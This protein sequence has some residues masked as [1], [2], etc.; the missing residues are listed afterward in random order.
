MVEISIKL[1]HCLYEKRSPFSDSELDGD[2]PSALLTVKALYIYQKQKVCLLDPF[3]SLYLYFLTY[4][5]YVI[6][7]EH[8]TVYKIM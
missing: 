2:I 7:E 4:R 6:Y 8:R 3:T 1:K 5:G